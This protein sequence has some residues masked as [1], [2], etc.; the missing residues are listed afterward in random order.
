M[1]VRRFGAL[2][3][4]WR[5]LPILYL[6][7]AGLGSLTASALT[8]P[9]YV[10]STTMIVQQE[11]VDQS[12]DYSSLL[13]GEK[14]ANTYAVTLHNSQ[15]LQRVITSLKLNTT[16]QELA[17]RV[18][19]TLVP[20]TQLITLSVED[21]TPDRAEAIANEIMRQFSQG[22]RSR[23]ATQ[24]AASRQSLQ[25]ELDTL[26]DDTARIQAQIA[27]LASGNTDVAIL[28]RRQLQTALSRDASQYGALLTNYENL[29][30]AEARSA[31]T[32]VAAEA[33]AAES[34]LRPKPV[35]DLLLA[36]LVAVVL[37]V[38]CAV[39]ADRLD[40]SIKSQQDIAQAAGLATLGMVAATN[41]P[42][43]LNPRTG[44]QDRKSS[45]AEA[46][47][48]LRI[49][50]EFARVDSP[51]RLVMVTAC[52]AGAGTSMVAS[53][54]AVI[55]AA[56]GQKVI[57]ID[58]N[59]RNSTQNM[60]F[61]Q[62]TS[63]VGLTTALMTSRDLAAHMLVRTGVDGLRL[64]QAGPTP[65]NP[66]ELLQSSRMTELLRLLATQADLVIIDTPALLTAPDAALLAS[67]C[68]SVLIVARFGVTS[69][70]TLAE[71]V[72]Q[73][74]SAGATTAGVVLNHAPREGANS[75]YQYY[76]S[77]GDS[78]VAAPATSGRL[79]PPRGRGT[80]SH[81]D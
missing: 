81:A 63:M 11:N 54:L 16:R 59:W 43:E 80:V 39:I 45:S 23:R 35:L 31:N 19:T 14:L 53:N 38:A 10:A 66:A 77:D 8:A 1:E 3:G 76:G 51:M 32:I 27:Q 20:D 58:A 4:R 37:S 62:P 78:G 6:C 29:R 15:L 64:M 7:V 25:N 44:L 71:A 74:R 79:L 61:G 55:A 50:L 60:I 67:M 13:T 46:F 2:M 48:L 24:F 57:I 42:D 22:I 52:Q 28:S 33:Q 40:N 47:R 17:H 18:K 72:E 30:I 12:S 56:N 26:Q 36:L 9:V 69:K 65:P 49:N 68:D 70:E 73:L 75:Y 5:W 41:S 21:S 34:P